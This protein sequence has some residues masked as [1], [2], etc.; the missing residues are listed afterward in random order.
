MQQPWFNVR[1]PHI[2]FLAGFPNKGQYLDLILLPSRSPISSAGPKR[3]GD[4]SPERTP[5][6]KRARL[7]VSTPSDSSPSRAENSSPAASTSMNSARPHSA[8]E[9]IPQQLD[10]GE[11][12]DKETQSLENTVAE[13]LAGAEAQDAAQV[14]RA[15]L[16]QKY[17]AAFSALQQSQYVQAARAAQRMGAN[18]NANLAAPTAPPGLGP[19]Q[20]P[21]HAQPLSAAKQESYPASETSMQNEIQAMQNRTATAPQHTVGASHIPQHPTLPPQ[22]LAQ[23]QNMMERQQQSRATRPQGPMAPGS[24]PFPPPGV[25]TEQTSEGAALP[26][27]SMAGS[28]WQGVLSWAGSDVATQGRKEVRAQVV[29]APQPGAELYVSPPCAILQRLISPFYSVNPILGQTCY[30]SHR[31]EIQRS[32]RLSYKP[33]YAEPLPRYVVSKA[34]VEEPIPRRTRPIF[35]V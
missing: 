12:N 19:H 33:G 34:T 5:D 27:R 30:N 25:G 9:R 15:L 2:L 1:E 13:A 11:Q 16:S 21:P 3:V 28:G 24:M 10:H 20:P 17:K 32:R 22:L 4:S 31:V 29:A 8:S 23:M 35:R 7:P 14:D 18:V 26:D 6:P